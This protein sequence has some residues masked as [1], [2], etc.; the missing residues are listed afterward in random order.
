MRG[1]GRMAC[2]QAGSGTPRPSALLCVLSPGPPV[3]DG[4]KRAALDPRKSG[5][6]GLPATVER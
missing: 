3:G 1:E 6:A 2:A 5:S 4:G